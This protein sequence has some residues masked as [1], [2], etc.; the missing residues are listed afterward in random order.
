MER[1]AADVDAVHLRLGDPDAFWICA[2]SSSHLTVRP[3]FVVV[4]AIRSTITR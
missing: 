2:L 4:A 1:G 3:V